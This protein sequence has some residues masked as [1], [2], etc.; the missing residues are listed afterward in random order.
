M[1]LRMIYLE[2]RGEFI[3]DDPAHAI[4]LRSEVKGEFIF[5]SSA[6]TIFRGQRRVY[7]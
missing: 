4:F 5:E 7:F 2:V 1:V 3:F 6:H